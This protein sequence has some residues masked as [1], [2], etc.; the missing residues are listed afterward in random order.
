LL[1]IFL[2][3]IFQKTT[4]FCKICAK[5]KTDIVSVFKN[6]ALK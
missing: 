4:G 6:M 3:D 1:I 5:K 2:I